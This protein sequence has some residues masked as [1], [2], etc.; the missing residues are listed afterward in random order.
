MRSPFAVQ[1]TRVAG[2]WRNRRRK[3]SRQLMRRRGGMTEGATTNLLHLR[4]TEPRCAFAI[5]L[6][7]DQL[8]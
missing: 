5:A 4:C 3:S 1:S 7:D 6:W 2:R 8:I